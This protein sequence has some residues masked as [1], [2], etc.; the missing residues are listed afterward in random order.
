M[1]KLLIEAIDYRDEGKISENDIVQINNILLEAIAKEKEEEEA[2]LEVLEI[3]KAEYGQIYKDV[4]EEIAYKLSL[5]INKLVEEAHKELEESIKVYEDEE[6]KQIEEFKKA[7]KSLIF[8]DEVKDK[9]DKVLSKYRA[10]D[11]EVISA[12]ELREII[13]F[14]KN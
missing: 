4:S 10:K 12:D 7:T 11:D 9:I 2:R 3:I 8:S 14:L 5:K 6:E 1:K 13:L